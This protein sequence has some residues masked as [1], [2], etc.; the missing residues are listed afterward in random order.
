MKKLGIYMEQTSANLI[1]LS[2]DLLKVKSNENRF[3]FLE[4]KQLQTKINNH[5]E[6][7]EPYLHNEYFKKLSDYILYY[8]EVLLFGKSNAKTELFDMISYDN[9]FYKIK[10]AI[11]HTNKM[12]SNQQND[13]VSNY[14]LLDKL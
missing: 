8:N 12:N 6:Y 7:K 2:I 5:L 11:K 3:N 13:F 4:G 14:F 9:R 10:I 1:E